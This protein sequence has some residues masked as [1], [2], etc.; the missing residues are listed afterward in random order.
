MAA[1]E[2]LS[3]L[4]NDVLKKEM[5]ASRENGI[6]KTSEIKSQVEAMAPLEHLGN[7]SEVPSESEREPVEEHNVDWFEPLEE[8]NDELSWDLSMIGRRQ[9]VE[10][11]LAGESERNYKR[12]SPLYKK[13]RVAADEGW[14]DWPVLG[15]G[16]KRKAVVRRSGSSMGQKDVY[17]MSPL[18]ERVR[19]RVELAKVMEIDLSLFEYKS[20]TFSNSQPLH[21]KRKKVRRDRSPSSDS[22]SSVPPSRLTPGLTPRVTLFPLR[23]S[24]PGTPGK[25]PHFSQAPLSRATGEGIINTQPWSPTSSPTLSVNGT[26]DSRTFFRICVRCGNSYTAT[27]LEKHGK[28]SFCPKCKV[29]RK[30]V[31]NSNIVFRKWIPCGQCVACLTT[32]NCGVCASCRHG[33]LNPTSKKPVRCRKRKCICPIR[34]NASQ[35]DYTI[36]QNEAVESKSFSYQKCETEDFSVY[37]DVDGEEDDFNDDDDNEEEWAKKR[38][39]R[40]CGTCNACL[41]R[42]DCGTCDFC[43]DKPKF[44]GSNKKRQKCRLRQCQR[45]A[46]RHLL[47]FQLGLG[48]FGTIDELPKF[49]RPKPHYTY[50]RKTEESKRRKRKVSLLDLE[51]TDDENDQDC[52]TGIV[53]YNCVDAVRRNVPTTSIQFLPAAPDTQGKYDNASIQAQDVSGWKGATQTMDEEIHSEEADEEEED[54]EDEDEDED[55]EDE[56]IPMITQIFS[57][58]ETSGL[59]GGSMDQELLKLLE[60]TRTSALPVLWYAIMKEGPQLQL[61]QCS[62]MSTMTDT[63]VQINPGFYYQVAVQ[64]QPLLLT[65]PLYEDHPPQM[66]SVTLVVNLLLDL[67]RYR[68]CQGVPNP[69]SP[70]N[71]KPFIFERASTCDFLILKDEH[72]CKKCSALSCL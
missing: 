61:V 46:M 19:S 62:K 17:Y 67:E 31:N 27:K 8:D 29:K 50:S 5:K 48:E 70:S 44:G 20:G 45:Q 72:S 56:V 22:S 18:N 30:P 69:E 49:G 21:G 58:A 40:A 42:K 3:K 4:F 43:I 36:L 57:L 6:E 63:V 66:T 53:E 26:E 38:K 15:E 16:W 12:I 64:G 13:K 65:H 33:T 68:V 37:V 35:T 34:K 52:S 41:S 11:G 47:P 71:K 25:E 54:E 39:R 1:H 9:A 59:N 24:T 60:A 23:R 7:V 28:K 32:V 55:E 14:E 2:G 51:L 10:G